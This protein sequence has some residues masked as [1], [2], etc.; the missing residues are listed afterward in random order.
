MRFLFLSGRLCL[1]FVHTG[2]EGERAAF[3]AW[4]GPGDLA[5]WLAES[6]WRLTGV[7]IS[8]ADLQVARALSDVLWALLNSREFMFNH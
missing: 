5:D 2:G 8:V 3:E 6:P 4:H 1:D 7:A